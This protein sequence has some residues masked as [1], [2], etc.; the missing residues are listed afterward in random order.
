M[1]AGVCVDGDAAAAGHGDDAG[2]S[3]VRWMHPHPVAMLL[4]GVFEDGDRWRAAV[5]VLG[6]PRWACKGC[7]TEEYDCWEYSMSFLAALSR[8]G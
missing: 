6:S 5:A 7:R 4:V 3:F 8:V 2:F 1:V